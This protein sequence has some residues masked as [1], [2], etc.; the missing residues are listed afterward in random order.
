[1]GKCL[2]ILLHFFMLWSA[3]AQVVALPEYRAWM[4][5]FSAATTHIVAAAGGGDGQ[6]VML[7]S[8][9]LQVR[10][11]EAAFMTTCS[12]IEGFTKALPNRV[13][14]HSYALNTSRLSLY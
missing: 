12:C 1:M 5:R 7:A 11:A 4:A 3:P 2:A 9:V 10:L 6:A 13:F 8:A 14:I